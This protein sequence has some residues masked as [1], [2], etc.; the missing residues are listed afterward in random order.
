MNFKFFHLL[1]CYYQCLRTLLILKEASSENLKRQLYSFSVDLCSKFSNEIEA[2]KGKAIEFD[3]VVEFLLN[4]FFFL[5]YNE[6]FKLNQGE[7]Y[8]ETMKKSR[9]LESME[10]RVLNVIVTLSAYS[11]EFTV[12]RIIQEIGEENI[13]LIYG[14][15]QSLI[16][17]KLILPV[18]F[19]NNNSNSLPSKSIKD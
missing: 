10:S 14:G 4:K 11:E 12:D 13:D 2:Y 3:D 9:E 8:I 1:I 19:K 6:P 15:L 18:Y 7:V 16:E 17:N 5:F